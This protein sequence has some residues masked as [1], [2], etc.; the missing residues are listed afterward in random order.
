MGRESSSQIHFRK[1]AR[2]AREDRGWSQAEMA[3]KLKGMGIDAM[4]GSTVAKIEAGER[5][6]K[7]DEATAM[8]DL[9]EMSL[10]ELVARDSRKR[11]EDELTYYLRQLRDNARQRAGQA[12][13][14]AWSVSGDIQNVSLDGVPDSMANDWQRIE[15]LAESVT[16]DLNRAAYEL[17]EIADEATSIL[18]ARA[19]KDEDE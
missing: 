10:D 16:Y 15:E 6:V 7:L 17:G 4:Y 12:A 5:E 2:M 13:D 3:R 11:R 9:F 1:K 19:A 18:S 8:A 14:L